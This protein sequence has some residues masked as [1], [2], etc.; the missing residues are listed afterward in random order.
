MSVAGAG[1]IACGV[2]I[3]AARHGTVALWAR[4]AASAERARRRVAA[5][6]EKLGEPEIAERVRVV[7][8]LDALASASWLVEAVAED[9]DVKAA[10][11][12]ELAQR[13]HDDAI[14]A[15]TTSSLSVG[16]L[17]HAA[18]V[19]ERFVGL[20]V[21]NP[22][23]RMELVELAFAP[24]ASARTRE[25]AHALCAALG[26]TAVDVPDTAGFVVNRLLFPY[27]FEAAELAERTGMP[28]ADVDRCMTLGAGHPMGPLA[29]LDFVGLDVSKAIGEQL[30]VPVP[31]ALERRIAAGELGRKS[32]RGFHAYG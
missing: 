31:A 17:A 13:A 19:P 7:T 26:K 30:G 15:T 29:L 18:G 6:A 3:V 27:L 9:R 25:R 4:S 12:G 8:D 10:V 11:L 1:A 2:A 23:W 28:A 24:E 32:G 5:A 22:V 20:H 21:F 16:E 14:L